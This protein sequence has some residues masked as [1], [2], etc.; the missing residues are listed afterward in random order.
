M[1]AAATQ[2]S[3]LSTPWFAAPA[4]PINFQWPHRGKWRF[5][6][7]TDITALIRR[8]VTLLLDSD[9]D[10]RCTRA[11]GPMAQLCGGIGSDRI[12]LIGRWPSD[13]IYRYL[14][15]QAQPVMAGVVVAMLRGGDFRL[16]PHPSSSASRQMTHPFHL[17]SHWPTRCNPQYTSNGGHL[18]RSACAAAL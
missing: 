16:N 18:E 5:I 13:K 1:A 15:V 11:G 17:W 10:A 14:H 8:A 4:T 7:A 6:F 2:R 9:L 12:R 3:V